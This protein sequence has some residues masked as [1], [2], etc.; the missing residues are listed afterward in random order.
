[1]VRKRQLPIVGNGA[2]VFSFLHVDDAASATLAAL[3]KG[4]GIYNVVDDE[5]VAARVWIPYL[6]GILGAKPPRHVPVWLARLLA[7]DA[8]ATMMTQGRGGVNDKAKDELHWKPM[9]ASWR[10]GFR[11]ELG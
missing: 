11:H 6:A 10:E 9:Y 7:G 8:A 1:M 2:G 5:P 4:T 3:T